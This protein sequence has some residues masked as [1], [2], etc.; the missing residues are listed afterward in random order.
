MP[1][2]LLIWVDYFFPRR[3]GGRA[4]ARRPGNRI[5]EVLFTLAVYAAVAITAVG[6]AVHR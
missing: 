5:M 6:W 3:G 1:G 2:A 4:S